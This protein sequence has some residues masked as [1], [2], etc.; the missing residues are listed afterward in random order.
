MKHL[1]LILV[2]LSLLISFT[3]QAT[4]GDSIV[5][6]NV[7]YTITSQDEASEAYEVEITQLPMQE[8]I[9]TPAIVPYGGKEY[10]VTSFS[11]TMLPYCAECEETNIPDTT[12]HVTKI[13]LSASIY[14]YGKEKEYLV[15]GG[16]QI[17]TLILPPNLIC[18]PY[19]LP[20]YDMDS[21]WHVDYKRKPCISTLI[22]TNPKSN[23]HTFGFAYFINIEHVD[24]SVVKVDSLTK[25][26]ESI[27]YGI[28]EE[29]FSLKSVKLPEQI[30]YIGYATFLNC[31]NLVDLKLPDSLEYIGDIA[32]G[33]TK[34]DSIYIPRK[35]NYISPNF[36][37]GS[38]FLRK[39]EVDSLNQRFESINGVLYT[40]GGDSI[41]SIPFSLP[42]D[43]LFFP[44]SVHSVNEY[45]FGLNKGVSG[46]GST[47]RVYLT[48]D[49]LDVINHLYV[50]DKLWNLGKYAFYY[51]PLKSIKNFENT[52]VVFI[53]EEC[54]AGSL[55]DTIKFPIELMSIGSRAFAECRNLK[56]VEFTREFTSIIEH[57]AFMHC[58]SLKELNL[59][60][61]TRLKKISKNLCM[62]DSALQVVKLPRS[63]EVIE[64]NAFKGCV[65]LDTIEVP[66]LEPISITEDVF[67]GV[68]KSRCTL[69]V[70]AITLEK[71][72]N[73]PV[74]RDF[75]NVEAGNMYSLDLRC[76]T[77]MGVVSGAGVYDLGEQVSINA[78]PHDGYYFVGWSDVPN[79]TQKWRLITVESD[80]T[81]TA[82]FV[83]EKTLI[84]NDEIRENIFVDSNKSLHIKGY[85]NC[86]LQIITSD[87]KL[88][89]AGK[90][91]TPIH[92]PHSGIYIIGIT[93]NNQ[94]PIY[95]K[96]VVK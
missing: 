61:Q 17:D 64:S 20:V 85:E 63:I 39:I 78:T 83:G 8:Y 41:H 73:A 86:N 56:Y 42:K 9:A 93:T 58:I 95:R 25:L 47:S 71:Y 55:L 31:Y 27:H 14:I 1:N 12:L 3:A 92:L 89:Y 6:E 68:D 66:I 32:L 52:H 44:E 82:H 33:G 50:N 29:A 62:Y 16:V 70:P 49:T 72:R 19:I 94:Q 81:I 43:T 60:R 48:Y 36:A 38:Y 76:D 23:V 28:F 7:L 84:V 11:L 53:P 37:S 79:N 59:S 35:V 2:L 74:W 40:K 15:S 46:T 5:Y 88:I 87:G 13:D 54:F 90:T 26:Q 57:G 69:V 45:A 77:T 18:P 22:L 51:S 67:E 75:F 24:M 21:K 10:K 34:L 4:V 91:R 96:I 65:S 30:K 80:T